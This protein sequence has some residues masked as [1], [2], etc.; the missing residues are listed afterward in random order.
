MTDCWRSN[1]GAPQKIEQRA[2]ERLRLLHVHE[3][4]GLGDDNE[5]GSRDAIVDLTGML[6][7]RTWIL[8]THEHHHGDGNVRNVIALIH[9]PDRSATAGETGGRR[10]QDTGAHAGDGCRHHGFDHS[11]RKS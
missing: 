11:E 8:L 3:M 9:I 4:L 5:R 7:R 10:L 1:R 6:D 2:I